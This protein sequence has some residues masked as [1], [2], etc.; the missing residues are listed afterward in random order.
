M[1][2]VEIFKNTKIKNENVGIFQKFKVQKWKTGG[3]FK[4]QKSKNGK[5]GEIAKTCDTMEQVDRP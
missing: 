4:N 3:N 1:E 5:L 2:N